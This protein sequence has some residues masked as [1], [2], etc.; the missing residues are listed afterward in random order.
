LVRDFNALRVQPPGEMFS[1]PLILITQTVAIQAGGH[2][3]WVGD[4]SC[5]GLE[6]SRD[7]VHLPPLEVSPA[8]GRDLRAA[9][10]K[11]PP[12][13]LHPVPMTVRTKAQSADPPSERRTW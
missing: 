3:W 6:V 4:E 9:Y 13:L 8:F 5:S 1:C 11:L 10:G 12:S 2:H 7:G